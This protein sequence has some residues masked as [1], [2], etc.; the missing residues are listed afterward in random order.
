MALEPASLDRLCELARLR[1]SPEER[2]ALGGDV[3]RVLELFAALRAAPVDGLEPLS[4][5]HELTLRLRDDRVTESDRSEA[6]LALSPAAQGGY[7][8]VPRVLE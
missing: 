8:L 4:H 2:L 5:P 7:Y 6:L 1:L 3:E